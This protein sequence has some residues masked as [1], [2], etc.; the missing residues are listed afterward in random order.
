MK[1]WQ[2]TIALVDAMAKAVEPKER[3]SARVVLFNHIQLLH[4]EIDQL[5]QCV[6]DQHSNHFYAVLNPVGTEGVFFKDK[7]NALFALQ[8]KVPPI[9]Q[10]TP[11]LAIQ[12]RTLYA[13]SQYGIL[14]G[15]SLAIVRKPWTG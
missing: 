1:D 8:G 3:L 12:F 7:D 13:K 9:M 5:R 6:A 15:V 2:K 10:G 4:A 14:D 11:T